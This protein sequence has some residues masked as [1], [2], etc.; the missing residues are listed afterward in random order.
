MN[1]KIIIIGAGP[2]GLGAAWRLQELKHE[3]WHLY[4]KLPYAG[5][6]ARSFYDKK[7][8]TWDIGVH[9]QFSHY[10]YFDQL[11]DKLLDESW[12]YHERESWVWIFNRFVPY[13]FQ[14][15]IKYLPKKETL[16]CIE[17]LLKLQL[18]NTTKKPKNFKQ[19][20][21]QGFGQ[22]IAEI[23]MLPYNFK[24]WAHPLKI[25]DYNWIGERVPTLDINRVLKNI[26]LGL[27]DVSWGPN[28]KFRFPQ[29]GGTGNIWMTLARKLDQKKISYNKEVEKI[30][31]KT[32]KIYFT[33]GEMIDYDY[34]VS[35]IPL[36][37]LI[38]KS[39]I[40]KLKPLKNKF[41]Y[42][43]VNIIGLGIKGPQPSV[44]CTK[45]WTYFPEETYPFYRV[46]YFSNYSPYNVPDHK[47]YWSLIFEVSQS[48]YRKVNTK[49]IV[50]QVIQGA[51]KAKMIKTKN[52]V[53]NT[54]QHQETHGYP[55][56]FLD[57]D[58]IVSWLLTILEKQGIYSRGRFGAWKYEVSNM[59][60]SVMQGVEVANYIVKRKKEYTVYHPEIVNSNRFK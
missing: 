23:F 15:N 60:H 16:K 22:R 8:F 32:K 55:T 52:D 41:K 54:W 26:I 4:E 46:T 24:V 35:T 6:L 7:G 43:T 58:K 20:I 48:K 14:Y 47:K 21:Y 2:C 17:S 28:N 12:Y 40:T 13:P 29:K 57:R 49:T 37:T 18:N 34:L 31:T 39:N 19:W 11:M 53:I 27:D 9:V 10:R 51:I 45:S 44:L 50:N 3:N 33:S 56:P 5:G 42:S 30:D 25:M 36:D 1:K 38:E 59:D